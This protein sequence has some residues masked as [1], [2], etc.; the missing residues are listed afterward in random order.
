[1][2]EM[3]MPKVIVDPAS[4]DSY[5]KITIEPLEKGFG[6]TLGN[7]MRRILLSSLP[8]AAVQGVRF[9]PEGLVKHE[10]SSIPNIK[11]DITEIILNLK[12]LAMG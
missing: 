12:T 5:V 8:G 1:M 2:I 4:N 11:E 10:F 6:L 3:D 9:Y 7:S